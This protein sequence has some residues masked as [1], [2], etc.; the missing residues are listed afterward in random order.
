MATHLA[1]EQPEIAARRREFQERNPTEREQIEELITSEASAPAATAALAVVRER[2]RRALA[3]G[4]DE[5]H[6]AAVR[7]AALEA[8]YL[9][10]KTALTA[11]VEAAG[12]RMRGGEKEAF[13]IL[14]PGSAHTIAFESALAEYDRVLEEGLREPVVEASK[15]SKPWSRCEL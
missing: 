11:A 15:R 4:K 10:A 13:W 2:F 6:V 5:K 12:D 1:K 8:A 7:E 3:K 9:A 14:A